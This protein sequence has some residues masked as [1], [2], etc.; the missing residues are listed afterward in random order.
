MDEELKENESFSAFGHFNKPTTPKLKTIN[1]II[2]EVFLSR[3][4]LVFEKKNEIKMQ[5][6]CQLYAC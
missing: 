2:V 5:I 4:L 3:L 1:L 6:H